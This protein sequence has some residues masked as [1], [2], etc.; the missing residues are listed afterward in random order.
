MVTIQAFK[1]AMA[2]Q[3][4]EKAELR[5]DLQAARWL[6]K[7]GETRALVR[8]WTMAAAGFLAG[9]VAMGSLVRALMAGGAL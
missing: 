7:Q 8:E 5:R 4:R 9:A 6:V 3:E 2:V 1:T